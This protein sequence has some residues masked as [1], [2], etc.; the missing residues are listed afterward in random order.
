VKPAMTPISRRVRAYGAPV[1]RATGT[2]TWFDPTVAFDFDAPAAPWFALGDVANLKRAGA[3]KMTP[4]VSGPKGAV[5]GQVRGSLEVRVTF[6]F[7]QWGKI[8]M[9]LAGGSQHMNVLAT[10]GASGEGQGSPV[11]A[12]VAV[13]AGSTASE[14]VLGT[15]AVDAFNY[16]D[17]I[18]CDVD[19]GQQTG[20]VGSPAAAYVNDPVDVNRDRD[21]LRRVTFNVARVAS[22]TSTALELDQP[23]LSGNPA[24]GAQIQKVVA[25]ADREGGSFFQE[26]SMLLAIEPESGGRVCFYYPRVQACSPAGETAIP[27]DVYETSAL[28]AELIA[29]PVKDQI[30]GEHVVCWRTYFP[31][32]GAELY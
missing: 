15:G 26:W 9:A 18:A 22:K 3:T 19:Y 28:H 32:S 27:C 5:A 2:P 31:A 24:V 30:D 4:M 1:D 29:L 25:F 6:D 13:L 16:G 17:M 20:Y 7:L 8:Q 23:L 14:L 10:N 12:P 11:C 21:Y